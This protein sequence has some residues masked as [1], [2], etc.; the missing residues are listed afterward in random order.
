[1]SPRLPIVLPMITVRTAIPVVCPAFLIVAEIEDVTPLSS[2]GTA[3]IIIFVLGD[4]KRAKPS[5][6][7]IRIGMITYTS[8]SI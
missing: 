6:I 1:M 8:V 7:V 4:E 2:G 5:P 3:L